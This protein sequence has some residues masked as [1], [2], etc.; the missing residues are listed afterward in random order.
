MATWCKAVNSSSQ[1]TC[2]VSPHPQALHSAPCIWP[3]RHKDKATPALFA[4]G[5]AWPAAV[6]RC[7]GYGPQ[8]R[9]SGPYSVALRLGWHSHRQ[10]LLMAG[11][12]S[13]HPQLAAAGRWCGPARPAASAWPQTK[14]DGGFW[15][16]HT[17]LSCLPTR[18]Q[19]L[20]AHHTTYAAVMR[21]NRQRSPTATLTWPQ[22]AERRSEQR[23]WWAA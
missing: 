19:L 5:H 11:H 9:L 21:P 13:R 15:S 18:R 16:G 7:A 20:G 14:G 10:R 12:R 8:R 23:T 3:P 2:K 1:R 22:R 17:L 4:S 6:P